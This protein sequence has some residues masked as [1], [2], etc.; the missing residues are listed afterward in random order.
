VDSLG[1]RKGRLEWPTNDENVSLQAL[2]ID[3][4]EARLHL[5]SGDEWSLSDFRAHFAGADFTVLATVTNASAIQDWEFLRTTS[6]TP[7]NPW[8]ERLRRLASVIERISYSTPPDLRLTVSGDARDLQSFRARFVLSAQDADTPWGKTTNVLLTARLLPL[9]TDTSPTIADESLVGWAKTAPRSLEWGCN[10]GAL[11]S[12]KLTAKDIVCSGTWKTPYLEVSDLSVRLG[13]G[14]LEGSGTLNATTREARFSFVSDADPYAVED[15]MTPKTRRWLSKFTWLSPPKLVC[16]GTV[17]LPAWTN[18]HPNWREEVRP[19]L[20][21][22]GQF[23]VTN[24]TYL[25]LQAHWARS[26]FTYTNMIWNLPDLEVRR[27]EGTL[28][29][30]H[31]A[32]ERT[33]DYHWDIHGGINPG[34]LRHLF[35]T[36]QL[37]RF[38][39]FAFTSLVTV[40]GDVWGRL[41]EYDRIGFQLQVA[42]TNFAVRGQSVGTFESAVRYTN[43]F[44]EFIQPNLTRGAQLMSASGVSVDFAAKRVYFTNG[45]SMADPQVVAQAI[46]PR[47][48]RLLEPY[49]FTQPPVGRVDGYAPL[50]GSIDADLHFVIDGGPF[51]WWKFKVPRIEGN[52]Y[53]RSNTLLI[54]NVQSEFYGGSGEGFGLFTF[55]QGGG[56]SFRF[57][58][59]VLEADLHPLM[60][61]LGSPSNRMEGVLSGVLAVTDAQST[62]RQ[63]WNGGGSV[64]LR[65]GF[66]WD[67]PVFGFLS[68][69]L[70][71]VMPG[72]GNSRATEG[73]AEFI[74][75]NS[76]VFS[77]SL[78]I[79]SPMMRLQYDGTVDFQGNV[80]ARV[81][82]QLL[83]DAWLVG[84]I[85]SLVLKPLTKLL[86]YKVTGTL[87]QPKPAPV[88]F[89]SRL[90]FLPLHPFRSLDE[91]FPDNSSSTNAPPVVGP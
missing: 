2:K 30:A 6:P 58:F 86:E 15:L 4:I 27:T 73:S 75:T 24:G 87:S 10:L 13:G 17:M 65:D 25:G 51:E 32:D 69:K 8:P 91:M 50:K 66:I 31:Q 82:A 18:R 14:K 62:N 78:N 21:L 74:I 52:V 67:I 36:N 49:R 42:A 7:A 9:G 77:D 33:K 55:E 41:Y 3:N 60:A 34:S 26:H 84:R 71:D 57:M 35:R 83:R 76:V 47:T 46:G 38:D 43:R 48:A 28:R 63:S 70:N 72:L 64:R 39:L 12:E 89:I 37:Q 59:D 5:G 44:L 16:S 11:S 40:D 19:T 22:A 80:D 1:L 54:T 85:V 61:D 45:F 53:W 56:S 23:A 20:H 68:P 79:R 90:I 29:L 81:E 88:Y